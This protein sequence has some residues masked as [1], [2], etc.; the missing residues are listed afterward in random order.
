MKTCQYYSASYAKKCYE[1]HCELFKFGDEITILLK[2]TFLNWGYIN[3]NIR[4]AVSKITN[5]KMHIH[6]DIEVQLD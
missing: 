4:G 6:I 1:H 3:G 2:S 5:T